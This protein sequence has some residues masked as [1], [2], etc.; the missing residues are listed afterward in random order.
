MFAGRWQFWQM[1]VLQ[2]Q[3][4]RRSWHAVRSE[5][6][7]VERPMLRARRTLK[8]SF[9]I[10]VVLS[11][12]AGSHTLRFKLHTLSKCWQVA[13]S[14]VR[15]MIGLRFHHPNDSCLAKQNKDV[16]RTLQQK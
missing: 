11:E 7:T 4:S 13:F 12:C 14:T 3:Q 16:K 1:D 2:R 15:A 6:Q 5:G 8:T 9:F 10:V